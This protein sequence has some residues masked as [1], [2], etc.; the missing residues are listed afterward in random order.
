MLAKAV[1][2]YV[3]MTPRK[4]GYLVGPLRKRSVAEALALLSTTNRRAARP[5]AKLVASAF[6]NARQRYPELRE[7]DVIISKAI[8]NEGPRWKRF[9]AAAFGRAARVLKRTT[10]ITVE[11]EKK[12]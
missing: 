6:A 11:L 12:A 8:A 1:A 9:R 7:D 10:H 2:R 3:R 5:V 4:V